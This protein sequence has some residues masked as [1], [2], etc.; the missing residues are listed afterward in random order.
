MNSL[1]FSPLAP[2]PAPVAKVLGSFLAWSVMVETTQMA[3]KRMSRTWMTIE[4]TRPSPPMRRQNG[5]LGRCNGSS[6]AATSAR[7]GGFCSG[8]GDAGS[9]WGEDID[10]ILRAERPPTI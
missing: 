10:L 2:P 7:T 1:A 3:A 5:S 9:S 4:V 8:E 6:V